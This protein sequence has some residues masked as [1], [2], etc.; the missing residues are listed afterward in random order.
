MRLWGLLPLFIFMTLVGEGLSQ[1]H[2]MNV[3]HEYQWKNRILLV[4]AQS[5][6]DTTF[7]TFKKQLLEEMEGIADRD[8]LIFEIFEIGRSSSD[9]SLLD[10][11]TVENL[12]KYLSIKPGSFAIILIGKD[13]NEK[14][15]STLMVKLVELF[16]LI[17]SMPMRQR[18]MREKSRKK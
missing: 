11:G 3:L 9:G 8:L 18:E 15:R 1:E 14:F 17:D 7:Q 16:S 12:R 2:G 6:G 5:E 10:A 13:G 4:F